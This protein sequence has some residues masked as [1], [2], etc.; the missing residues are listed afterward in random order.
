MSSR[1]PFDWE[2]RVSEW[3]CRKLKQN[4][5]IVVGCNAIG[6]QR[7]ARFTAM[8]DRPFAP[9]AYPKRDWFHNGT[10]VSAS[11]TGNIVQVQRMD[12]VGAVVAMV[13]SCTFGLNH[14]RTVP[15]AER[16]VQLT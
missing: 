1:E 2:R 9:L 3:S 8:D 10:A 5:R 7:S 13:R 15:A 6:T 11:V 4:V 14:N 12:A 16:L